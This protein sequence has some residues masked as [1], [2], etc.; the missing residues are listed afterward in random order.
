MSES[1]GVSRRNVL[2]VAG[3]SVAATGVAGLAGANGTVE[4]NV[5]YRG[6]AARQAALDASTGVVRDFVSLDVLTVEASP[7]AAQGLAERKHVDFVEENGRMHALA[8]T[9]PWGV[10]RVDAERAHA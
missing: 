8:Q 5:G 10:D 4:I 2:K 9:L 7:E 1:N 6:E 3:G